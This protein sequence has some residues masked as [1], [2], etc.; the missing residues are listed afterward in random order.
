MKPTRLPCTHWLYVMLLSKYFTDEQLI[1]TINEFFAAGTETT[2][3]TLRWALLFLIHHPDWQTKLQRD[4][5]EVIGQGH[6]KME[7]K[8]QLPSV[9]VFT[10]EVQRLANVTPH[11]VPHAPTEDFYYKG[12]FIPKGTFMTISLDSVMNDPNIFPEPDKFNPERF[13][14]DRGVCGGE[15]KDKFLPFSAGKLSGFIYSCNSKF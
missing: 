14:N 6:P 9:E 5:D 10:L 15:Q 11:A 12:Y 1:I 2:S 4:I 7:H 8:E 3:T 13:L